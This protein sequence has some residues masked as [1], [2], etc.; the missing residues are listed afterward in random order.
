MSLLAV[1]A[2][3]CTQQHLALCQPASTYR[4]EEELWH[5]EAV[6]AYLNFLPVRQLRMPGDTP[7]A[8]SRCGLGDIAQL[9]VG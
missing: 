8:E 2:V 4:L 5:L 6:H 9:A 3:L 7:T 1:L